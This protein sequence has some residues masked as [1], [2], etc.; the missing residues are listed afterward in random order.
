M[1]L[2]PDEKRHQ[3]LI[4]EMFEKITKQIIIK[5]MLNLQQ[6]SVTFLFLES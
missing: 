5:Y 4:I 2:R 1:S 6:L 3:Y